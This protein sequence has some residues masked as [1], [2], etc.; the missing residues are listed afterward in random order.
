MLRVRWSAPGACKALCLCGISKSERKKGNKTHAHHSRQHVEAPHPIS[1]HTQFPLISSKHQCHLSPT[2]RRGQHQDLAPEPINTRYLPGNMVVRK[3]VSDP[4]A[5]HQ[6]G[7]CRTDHLANTHHHRPTT[8]YS[9]DSRN[10]VPSL[11]TRTESSGLRGLSRHSLRTRQSTCESACRCDCRGE[12][13]SESEIFDCEPSV[14]MYVCF[15]NSFKSL[16]VNGDSTKAWLGSKQTNIFIVPE[17][18]CDFTHPCLILGVQRS[19]G[20]FTSL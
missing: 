12:I 14:T 16:R 17:S 5:C 18:V 10:A 20:I 15:S 4:E 13:F 3:W 7:T 19:L 9:A 8:P 2:A 6:C 1:Q 11:E